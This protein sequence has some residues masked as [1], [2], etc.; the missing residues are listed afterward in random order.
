MSP[1][2]T[3][4]IVVAGY[5][6]G[7]VPF[8]L[9]AGRVLKGIDL[10]EHGS[11][12]LGATNALRVLGKPAGVTVLLLDAAKGGLPVVLAPALL[13]AAP[14]WLPVA[15]AAAAIL[16]HVFPIYLRFKGG[17]GVATSAGAFLALH[18]AAFGC[19]VA[20]FAISL[21]VSRIVSL[22]SLSAAA[23]LPLAAILLDGWPVASGLQA[24]R[25][26]L[27]VAIGVLVFVRHRAN[28]GRLL[29][30]QEPRLGQKKAEQAEPPPDDPSGDPSGEDLEQ[31]ASVD[32]EPGAADDGLEGDVVAD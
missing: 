19:A 20:V 31:T 16:G 18:P 1:A 14:P 4:L 32:L 8:A 17:K 23:A 26:G 30:G 12:N 27:L 5:L 22:S 10:R 28:I 6:L 7:A 25:T 21:A 15:L 3:A 2:W 29:A 9:L 11:G 24:P 13:P